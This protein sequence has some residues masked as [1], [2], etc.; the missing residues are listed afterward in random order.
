VS[1][2]VRPFALPDTIAMQSNFGGLGG[3]VAQGHGVAAG[4][5]EA[6][7]IEDQYIDALLAH[8]A[9]PSSLG[10]VWPKWTEG[11]GMDDSATGE[12]L[13]KMIEERH[14]NSLNIPFA[15]RDKPDTCRAY[16]KDLAAYLREKGWLDLGYIYLRDEPNDAEEYETVRQQGALIASSDPGIGRMCTEQTV[17]SNAAWGDLYGAVDIWCPLWGLWDEK[18]AQERQALGE[19]MWSYTALCQCSDKN[20]YWQIDFPPVSFRAPFWVSRHY[21]I[22][23]F[24]YWS[25]VYWPP[26]KDPWTLP[27]FRDNY[28]GE[29]MLLYPG[30]PAGIKGPVTSIRLK[31]VR[32]ALEDYE[33]MALADKAGAQE[34]VGEIVAGIATNFQNWSREPE[35]YM[36]ARRDL[37]RLCADAATH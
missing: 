36:N 16:L 32:E 25:S 35:A 29:G 34:R 1:L 21:G 12:R 6:A 13:R 14:V 5:A 22:E 18:T 15:Y 2:T 37:A 20:P 8:R 27:H 3:R 31:L 4:S 23:G 7:E 9:I 19:R 30:T 28:W 11:Q 33:Y 24:L 26:E 17:T 10:N